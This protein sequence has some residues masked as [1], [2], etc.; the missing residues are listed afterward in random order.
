[1]TDDGTALGAAWHV[2]SDSEKFRPQS[3][4]SM[5][6]GPKYSDA[7]VLARVNKEKIFFNTPENPAKAIAELLAG[8]SIVAVF[9]G[10]VEFGPRSLG[11]RSI[12]AQAT[13]SDINQKLNSLLNRTEFMPFAPMTRIEDAAICYQGIERVDHAAEFMTVTVKCTEFMKETCPAVVHVDGTARPQ[14][15]SADVNP[16]IHQILTFYKQLTRQLAIVNTSFNVHEEPIVC[17]PDDALRGF[18]ESGLDYL[19]LEGVGIISFSDNSEVAIRY[20]QEKLKLKSKK[21]KAGTPLEQFLDSELFLRS[22]RLERASK[23]LHDRT[24]ELVET[25]QSLAERTQRLE[26]A[27][28]DL[29]DRTQELVETRQSVAER[30]QRLERASKDLYNRTQELVDTRQLLVERTERL[31]LLRKDLFDK[32]EKGV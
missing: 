32:T 29:Y 31:E 1:M 8:G 9:Q 15:V 14:L 22:E 4:Q 16:L 2:I 17:S 7:A 25:R 5:F 10:A 11:N 21:T 20:L 18:F 26:R 28:K 6:L 30:T 24:Q 27:S 13:E 3:L 19:Y 23:D 12:L